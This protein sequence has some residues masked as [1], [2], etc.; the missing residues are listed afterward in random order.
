M[1]QP[2][3]ERGALEMGIRSLALSKL[4]LLIPLKTPPNLTSLEPR[5]VKRRVNEFWRF[6]VRNGQEREERVEGAFIPLTQKRAVTALRL[7]MSGKIP[8]TPGSPE[9]PGKTQILRPSKVST[10]EYNPVNVLVER[11][12]SWVLFWQL[13]HLFDSWRIHFLSLF[14][15]RRS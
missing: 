4:L 6:A 2:S 5:G 15:V 7:K 13:E 9:T 3:E 14:I 8:E 10:Q 1:C 12:L 11:C